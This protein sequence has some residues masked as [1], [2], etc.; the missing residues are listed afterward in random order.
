MAVSR[1]FQVSGAS[2]VGTFNESCC[3]AMASAASGQRAKT[4]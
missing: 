1:A 3:V 4:I 2:S